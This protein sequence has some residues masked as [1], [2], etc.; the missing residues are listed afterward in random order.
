MG[1]EL[2]N[3]LANDILEKHLRSAAR[4][5][6]RGRLIDIGCGEKPYERLMRPYVREHIGV[7]HADTLHDTSRVDLFGTAYEIPSPDAAFDTALCTAVLEHLEEP[8][9]AIEECYR[10]LVPGGVAIYSVPFIWHIHEEPRDFY[11]YTEYGLRY[12]FEAT[13]FEIVQLTPLSGFW[14]TAGAMFAYYLDR[15]NKGILRTSRVV[16]LAILGVQGIVSVFERLDRPTRWTWMYLLVA[17]RPD[18]GTEMRPE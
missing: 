6:A 12:L 9:A 11:R 18:G 4:T 7:D 3:R 10:V 17:R 13:G 2:K 1:R 15:A 14:V 16:D 5:H 8:K